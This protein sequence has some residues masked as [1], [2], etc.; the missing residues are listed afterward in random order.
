VG[1]SCDHTLDKP[2][3]DSPT[4]ALKAGLPP[5]EDD[6]A[7]K[8]LL[9][10]LAADRKGHI[11]GKGKRGRKEPKSFKDCVLCLIRSFITSYRQLQGTTRMDTRVFYEKAADFRFNPD[12]HGDGEL[13]QHFVDLLFCNLHNKS[14]KARMAD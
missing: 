11:L 10:E 9:K 14:S 5:I 3:P 2:P 1:Q 12:C 7:R 4:L 13:P 6:S 8:S